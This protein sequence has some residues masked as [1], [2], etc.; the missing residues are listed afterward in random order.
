MDC[1]SAHNS[2]VLRSFDRLVVRNHFRPLSFGKDNGCSFWIK[3]L[4][5]MVWYINEKDLRVN[6]EKGLCYRSLWGW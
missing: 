4:L 2:I 5:C 6:D 1:I 3:I